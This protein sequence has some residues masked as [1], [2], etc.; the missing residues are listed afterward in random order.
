MKIEF[1]GNCPVAF[2]KDLKKLSE[3][4]VFDSV[5]EDYSFREDGVIIKDVELDDLIFEDVVVD[6]NNIWFEFAPNLE[7]KTIQFFIG[8]G[9]VFVHRLPFNSSSE[10]MILDFCEKWSND[11]NK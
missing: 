5:K 11:L 3:S 4:G 2:F 7:T 6:G 1:H 8:T 9:C 10:K